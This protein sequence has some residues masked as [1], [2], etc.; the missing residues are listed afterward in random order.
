MK[1]FSEPDFPQTLIFTCLHVFLLINRMFT[2]ESN[3]YHMLL[4]LQE[5]GNEMQRMQMR[6]KFPPKHDIRYAQHFAK[7]NSKRCQASEAELF[8]KTT[9]LEPL[10]VV[11]AKWST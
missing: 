7:M 8:V 9:D 1:Y 4:I 11:I 5:D 3:V 10:K 6:M 2:N